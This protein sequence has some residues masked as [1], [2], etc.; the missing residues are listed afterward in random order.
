M[1]QGFPHMDTTG[2]TSHHDWV[3]SLLADWPGRVPCKAILVWEVSAPWASID[4]SICAPGPELPFPRA[5]GSNDCQTSVNLSLTGSLTPG[6]RRVFPASRWA[7]LRSQTHACGYDRS[8][9]QN[10]AFST[11]DHRRWEKNSSKW[12]GW[13][14]A[15][16]MGFSFGLNTYHSWYLPWHFKTSAFFGHE[17][18]LRSKAPHSTNQVPLVSR[19]CCNSRHCGW[20]LPPHAWDIMLLAWVVKV[21]ASVTPFGSSPFRFKGPVV[22]L[23]EKWLVHE[24]LQ[25]LNGL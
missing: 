25:V 4:D 20:I 24:R 9:D 17:N 7:R 16:W 2:S 3:L 15:R 11:F 13:M 12:I 6:V 5:S 18:G 8:P 23:H 14:E 21:T 10:C 22:E 19:C 1:K